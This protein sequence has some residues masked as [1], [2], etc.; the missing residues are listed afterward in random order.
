MRELRPALTG[1]D[2][3]VRRVD[4]RQ[5][6][7][8]YRLI[9]DVTDDATAATAVA[10]FRIGDNLAWGRHLQVPDLSHHFCRDL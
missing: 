6:R 10:G 9:G 5:R 7:A 8:G 1:R 3:F 2:E 4:D